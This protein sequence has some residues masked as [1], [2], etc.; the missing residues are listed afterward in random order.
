MTTNHPAPAGAADPTIHDPRR[1]R[2]I[3]IAVCIALMAVIASVSGL[4][5]AQPE[6][7]VEFGAFLFVYVIARGPRNTSAGSVQSV[8]AGGGVVGGQPGGEEA[9]ARASSA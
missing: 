6:L 8:D 4:N 3:L 5:V 7:A 1:R 2:A 9:S